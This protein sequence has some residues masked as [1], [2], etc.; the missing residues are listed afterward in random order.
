[1][2]MQEGIGLSRASR[3]LG[4][5]GFGAA[6]R[7]PH[8]RAYLLDLLGDS[9]NGL[10]RH[11][12]A[13][14]A[15]Q[16]AAEGFKDQG[17]QCSH[18]LCLF[19]IADSYLSLQEPWHAIGYLKACLPLLRDLGLVRYE[20]LAQ[21]RLVTCEAMLAEARLL[22]ERRAGQPCGRPR[23]SGPAESPRQRIT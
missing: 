5:S 6:L 23:P 4:D 16:Q 12:A 9:H 7:Q 20:A 8:D 19:K 1:M 18:A 17:A 15:Y 10:G 3:G 14:D 21:H 13:I 2:T 11:G 22:G